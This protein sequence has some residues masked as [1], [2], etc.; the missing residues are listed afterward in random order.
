MSLGGQCAFIYRPPIQLAKVGPERMPIVHDSSS[1]VKPDLQTPSVPHEDEGNPLGPYAI[2]GLFDD[3]ELQGI[4]RFAAEL[5]DCPIALVSLVEEERQRFVARTGLAATETLR[6]LSFC[7][8]AMTGHSVMEVLDAREDDRFRTNALVVGEPNIR[9]YAGA[10]LR[11]VQGRP[12]GSLCVISPEPRAGLTAFQRQGLDVLA[13]A[14]M[15]FLEDRR[16]KLAHHIWEQAAEA[17]LAES[18]ERFRVLADAMPQMAWSTRPDGY[19]DYYNARWYDFTGATPGETAGNGWNGQFHPDDQ[20][21]AWA[22]WR[23]SLETGEPYEIEYRLRR[24]DGAYR[25]TL[26]RALPMRDER[27]SILRWFGTCT[28]IHDQRMLREQQDLLSRELGHRIKNI[29]MVVTSLLRLSG[30]SDPALKHY[31]LRLSEQIGALGRAYDYVRPQEGA[32]AFTLQGM[33]RELFAA[34]NFDG[35]DRV[36]VTGENVVLPEKHMTPLALTFHE[37]AT[38]AVKYGALASAEGTVELSIARHGDELHL[39]WIERGNDVRQASGHQG[40]GSELIRASIERQLRGTF[41]REWL[42]TG[43]NAKAVIPLGT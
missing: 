39:D 17:D 7:A 8:H 5:C 9:F 40:F 24:A 20:E 42:P 10:P 43:L 11:S 22:V 41:T 14:V 23:H 26:G 34:Y 31:A 32:S 28:D 21:R 38:N 6:S 1:S 27:G 25:W 16:E 33:L 35:E 15:R 19:H 18:E 29:F 36:R 3:P 4:T 37:L 13:G 30:R 12:L 2:E